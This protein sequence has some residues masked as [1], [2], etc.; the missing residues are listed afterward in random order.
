MG[1]SRSPGY[2]MRMLR[3]DCSAAAAQYSPGPAPAHM[4]RS[5][6]LRSLPPAHFHSA[7]SIGR[8]AAKVSFPGL[9]RCPRPRARVKVWRRSR[10]SAGQ[11]C[12]RGLQW[13]MLLGD[14]MPATAFPVAA[15]KASLISCAAMLHAPVCERKRLRKEL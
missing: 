1:H 8:F 9:S 14:G 11:V 12:A 4:T 13:R 7:L 6:I 5:L 10:V 15:P 3:S 2:W